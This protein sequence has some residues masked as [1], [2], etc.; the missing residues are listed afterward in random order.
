M[1]VEWP[2]PEVR[3]ARLGAH[4]CVWCGLPLDVPGDCI[5]FCDDDHQ[6]AWLGSRNASEVG[7][8]ADDDWRGPH[9]APEPP[10]SVP[11][12]VRSEPW[13]VPS[14]PESRQKTT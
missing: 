9:L 8:H 1:G 11:S 14:G 5:A 10:G 2:A 4:Q 12:D 7:S 3:D 6:R 13:Y